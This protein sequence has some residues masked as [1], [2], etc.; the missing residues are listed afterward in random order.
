MRCVVFYIRATRRIEY[1]LLQVNYIWP[2]RWS[3]VKV[4]FLANRYGGI[5][6]QAVGNAQQSGFFRGKDV[7]V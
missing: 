2:S 1:P 3:L 7:E 6:M 5:A 4:M